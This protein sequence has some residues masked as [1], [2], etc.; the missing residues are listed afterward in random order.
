MRLMKPALRQLALK[1]GNHCCA[2]GLG[3][4]LLNAAIEKRMIEAEALRGRE[5]VDAL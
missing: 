5:A 2:H 3:R 1:I 4:R